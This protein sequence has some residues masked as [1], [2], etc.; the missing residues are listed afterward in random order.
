MKIFLTSICL[1][2]VAPGFIH[3]DV[4]LKV[5]NEDGAI[6]QIMSNG[7]K[8]RINMAPEPGYILYDYDKKTMHVVMPEENKVM[9]M[10]RPSTPETDAK[11]KVKVSLTKLG[12][13]EKIAG[14]H[15]QKYTLKA[16]GKNCGTIYGSQ[17]ALKN[18]EITQLFTGLQEMAKSQNSMM[19]GLSLSQDA[20]Q[21]ADMELSTYV[22]T[23][24]IP[25]RSLDINGAMTSDVVSIDTKVTLSANNFALPKNSPISSIEEEMKRLQR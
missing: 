5:K 16:N 25:L 6:T 7:K 15:T 24:G 13:G 9:D 11:N 21:R 20:C 22:K 18:P 10:T 12:S 19:G 2:L 3:A 4:L 1:L 8:A 14:Y 17:A 23:L